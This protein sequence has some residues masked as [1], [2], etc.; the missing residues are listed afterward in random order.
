MKGY[1]YSPAFTPGQALTFH[2]SAPRPDLPRDS[3][4]LLLRITHVALNPADLV[5]LRLLPSWIPL[6]R[7]NPVPG[8]DFA[9]EVVEIGAG[10]TDPN[11]GADSSC[12]IK[13][14]DMVCGAVGLKEVF[15]GR[16][17]LAEF[18]AVESILVAKVPTGW[19]GGEAAGV[20]GI[21]GQ[22]AWAMVKQVVRDGSRDMA[23][24]RVLINGASGGVGTVLVQICKGFGADV[25]A[26][27]SGVNERLVRELGAS[28]VIDYRAHAVLEDVITEQSGERPFDA[29]FDCVGVQTLYEHSPRYL[30]PSGQFINIVGGWSQGVVPFIR[31]KMRPRLLGGTPRS[32]SLFL[33]SASGDNAREV[34]ALVEQD[35]IKRAVIDSEFLLEQAVEAFEKLATGRAKGKVIIRVDTGCS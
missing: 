21:A 1:T 3:T 29:I 34:A 2:S 26:V 28:E 11:A 9:G 32:Y 31:N 27:C 13:V 18:V 12:S 5:C 16:G 30:K 35:V 8:M 22:T 23:G 20:M 25:A 19:G 7:S 33:L 6:L 17:T 4:C 24:M 15:T 10:V 14:G